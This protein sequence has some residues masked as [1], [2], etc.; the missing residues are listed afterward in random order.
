MRLW[1]KREYRPRAHNVG[2]VEQQRRIVLTDACLAAIRSCLAEE[3]RKGH[4]GIAYLA[5]LTNGVTTVAVSAVRP[6][7]HTT[8]G[9]FTVDAAAMASVV[10]AVNSL[11]LQ[12]VGQVHTHLEDAFHSA[13]DETGATIR[14]TGYASIVLPDYGRLL[15]E[16]TGAAAYLFVSG[17]GFT[18][19]E[20]SKVTVAPGRIE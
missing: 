6:R 20:M 3:I 2:R 4:E 15:P 12:V 10:R 5:G 14:Y 19:V 11:G 8:W 7:A 13:G 16:L 18:V 9:S 17:E 1:P